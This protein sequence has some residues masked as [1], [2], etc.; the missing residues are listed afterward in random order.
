MAMKVEMNEERKAK[1]IISGDSDAL[2][3]IFSNNKVVDTIEV[4]DNVLFDL[5]ENGHIVSIE[6]MGIKEAEIKEGKSLLMS[7]END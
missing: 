3:A 6:I 7:E 1:L 2:L 5:D 4:A